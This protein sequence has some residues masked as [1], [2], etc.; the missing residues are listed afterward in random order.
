MSPPFF[1]YQKTKKNVVFFCPAFVLLLIV[2]SRLPGAHQV[3]RGK[4]DVDEA[5]SSRSP[6]GCRARRR[7]P[8]QQRQEEARQARRGSWQFFLTR[9]PSTRPNW[10]DKLL[11]TPLRATKE[12]GKNERA[13]VRVSTPQEVEAKSWLRTSP[14]VL[15]RQHPAARLLSPAVGVGGGKQSWSARRDTLPE[16]Q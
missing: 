15:W 1:Y 6:S 9:T 10:R 13:H 12:G 11:K 14:A 3:K 16:R 4:A 7:A 5:Y 2:F 8:V